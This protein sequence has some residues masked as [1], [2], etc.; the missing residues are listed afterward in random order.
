ML[1]IR[2]IVESP[3]EPERK[4]DAWLDISNGQLFLKFWIN[5]AW[6]NIYRD[7]EINPEDYLLKTDADKK[8]QP[9]G[10]YALKSDLPDL[11]L[12]ATIKDLE[13]YQP[14][15]D[16][17]LNSS[18]PK[19]VSQLEND[20]RF[21]T[22]VSTRDISDMS[23]LSPKIDDIL[24]YDGNKWVNIPL[25]SKV[26]PDLSDYATK[27]WVKQQGFA[28]ATSL[29]N[30]VD[31]IEGY[32]L[33]KN[34]FSDVLLEKL[35]S[36]EE[37]ANKYI[38]PTGGANTSIE[39][40]RGKVLS[41]ITVNSL[42][43][44]ISVTNKDLIEDDI[45]SLSISKITGL[46]EALDKK[47][48]VDLGI[49][50]LSNVNINTPTVGD[51][52]MFDGS[53]W[54][55]TQQVEINPDLS[56]YATM[57]WV[58]SQNYI[59]ST[60]LNAHTENNT[61]H[62]SSDE[63]TKWDN[64]ANSINSIM[65]SDSDQ[66]INKWDEIVAFL[67]T[68]TEA[69]TLANL[70]S[71]KLDKT[72]FTDLFEKVNIGSSEYPVY[73]VKVKYGLYSDE[74]ISSKKPNSGGS[75]GEEGST[76][77]RLDDW[78]SYTSDKAGWVLSAKLGNEL[79]ARVKSIETNGVLSIQTNGNGNV[80]TSI[81]KSGTIITITKGITALTEHQSLDAY[82]KTATA[83]ST[84]VTKLGI[85]ENQIGTY[86]NGQL[87]NLITVPY[88][89][90]SNTTTQLE[91]FTDDSFTNGGLYI[92]AIKES[93][94][95]TTRLWT[96]YKN[97]AKQENSIWVYGADKASNADKLNN[98]SS[99]DFFRQYVMEGE[100]FDFNNY[101]TAGVYSP[102]SF[103]STTTLENGPFTTS[104]SP[105]GFSLLSLKYLT[106]NTQIAVKYGTT[107]Y[108]YVRNS[109]WAT[110]AVK[111]FDWREIAFI[112]SNVASATKLQT[113]RTL[114]GQSFDGTGNVSGNMTG[115]GSIDANDIIRAKTAYYLYNSD[116]TYRLTVIINGAESIAKLYVVGT[117]YGDLYI[118]NPSGTAICIKGG[119]NIG[120]GNSNP[121][122]KCDVTGVVHAT[123]G[124]FTE[125]YISAKT[126]ISTSDER[127]KTYIE[128]VRLSIEDIANA[129]IW[130]FKWNSD[131][132][133]DIGST[134]QYW[135]KLI[136]ESV[137]LIPNSDYY[138]LDY[139]KVA[140][141]STVTI[142]NKVINHES[143]IKAL[144]D[145]LKN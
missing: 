21:L 94:S 76:Y 88:A 123:E 37:G 142:A 49:N 101:K 46:Q 140:L 86:V 104:E 110:N 105:G 78:S 112:D 70:L 130:R 8:Y 114:W 61:I 145:K 65:G 58:N 20:S 144:E 18:I 63:R 50:D 137:N 6:T 127:L 38:H 120:I 113:A 143:R 29:E 15:G 7:L 115:V 133:I 108:L 10:N 96:C 89:E 83:N 98:L 107:P 97:G 128:D 85:L 14:T 141:I 33:S 84:F 24:I 11:S 1:I 48:E 100:S 13:K 82:L 60:I 64:A 51:L 111:W 66:V 25:T 124:I 90:E 121:A 19:K 134:A 44:V 99:S 71:N 67:D 47:L 92:K 132:T 72:D 59:T 131:N 93:S 52:L 3:K 34:D 39:S 43:H 138:G 73:A 28:L 135:Q 116:D 42:G 32:G 87:K 36:I 41:S 35:D 69:D 80:I 74:F 129:P 77:S 126:Q 2:N 57:E 102:E 106:Y 53:N 75:S 79:N 45:P 91:A 12:Y 26:N 16:Y 103:S 30:K 54:I 119:T 56:D 4:E 118:G 31:K 9:L 136:P 55:N 139:S 40:V 81:E 62:I 5:G 109:V 125:G 117:N 17:A 22:T 68:F 27:E 23:V 122:Y 95:L